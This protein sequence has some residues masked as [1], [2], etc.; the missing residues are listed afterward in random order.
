MGTSFSPQPVR[1]TRSNQHNRHPG[2]VPGTLR[3]FR[4]PVQ[5]AGA[6]RPLGGVLAAVTDLW[7]PRGR[8]PGAGAEIDVFEYLVSR[9]DRPCSMPFT[10]TATGRDTSPP[11]TSPASP[12]SA[13]SGT[14]SASSGQRG[15]MSSRSMGAKPGA[16]ATVCLSAPGLDPSASRLAPGPATSA[17]PRCPI[18]SWSITCACTSGATSPTGGTGL[19][20][21]RH[22]RLTPA[23]LGV[24][25]TRRLPRRCRICSGAREGGTRPHVSG[26]KP[27]V[28]AGTR[29]AFR[30]M[31]RWPS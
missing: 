26:Q 23:M 7:R 30:T 12:A 29:L 9:G 18:P 21:P 27:G 24:P 3:L 28:R 15:S 20:S 6:T 31:L 5:G 1:A 2:Q 10:G 17:R 13:R 11:S 25:A 22:S 8:L 14:T 19:E 16:R 4:V